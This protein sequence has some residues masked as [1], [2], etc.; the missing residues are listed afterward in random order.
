MRQLDRSVFEGV[1]R[2]LEQGVVVLHTVVGQIIWQHPL[3]TF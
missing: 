1:K 3:F 2:D